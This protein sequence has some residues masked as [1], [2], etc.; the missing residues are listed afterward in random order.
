MKFSVTYSKQPVKMS[1]I[2]PCHFSNV[3]PSPFWK[4]KW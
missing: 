1:A 3:F 2:D 4:S